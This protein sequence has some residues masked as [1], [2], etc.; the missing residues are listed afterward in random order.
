M[1]LGWVSQMTALLDK[2]EAKALYRI[3]ENIANEY[4]Q[5]KNHYFQYFY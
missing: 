4:P 5:V 1:F 2:K 3:V